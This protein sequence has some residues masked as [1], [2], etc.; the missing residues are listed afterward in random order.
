[1]TSQEVRRQVIFE[2]LQ[3]SVEDYEERKLALAKTKAR[4]QA[5]RL[6]LKSFIG[7]VK[8]LFRLH[9]ELSEQEET[10][11]LLNGIARS[12]ALLQQYEEQQLTYAQRRHRAKKKP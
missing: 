2:E 9:P 7:Y 10:Q 11:E 6:V 1:M 4:E 3:E 8:A 5:A 12:E